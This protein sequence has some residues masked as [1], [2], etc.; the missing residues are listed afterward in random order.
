MTKT[1]SD[2][3]DHIIAIYEV[4]FRREIPQTS[5]STAREQSKVLLDDTTSSEERLILMQRLYK[6]ECAT[7]TFW[8]V[9]LETWIVIDQEIPGTVLP[10]VSQP[11][12]EFL[13][14][15]LR[16]FLTDFEFCSAFLFWL[17]SLDFSKVNTERY[18]SVYSEVKSY[19][20]QL[21]NARTQ[22]TG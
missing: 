2:K 9:L 8:Q 16:P 10:F 22:T 15:I 12:V 3:K 13:I 21:I 14:C 19:Y 5:R 4:S 7:Q 17:D 11:E 6:E 18:N 1:I 20:E